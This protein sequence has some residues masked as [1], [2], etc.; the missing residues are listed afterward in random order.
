ML[1]TLGR[2]KWSKLKI[3]EVYAFRAYCDNEL[4]VECKLNNEG[5]ALCLSEN[6][7][8]THDYSGKTNFWTLDA[9]VYK[10]STQTQRLWRED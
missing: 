8:G 1:K 10:L 4:H 3:N 7:W 6:M 9:H 5:L 2:V